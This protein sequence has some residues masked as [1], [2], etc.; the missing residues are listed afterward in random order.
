MRRQECALSTAFVAGSDILLSLLAVSKRYN[1]RPSVI[2]GV[3]NSYDAYCLDEACTYA[4][5]LVEEGRMPGGNEQTVKQL[6]GMKGVEFID[7]SRN[8]KGLSH[9]QQP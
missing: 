6:I 4:M 9:A 3:E 2:V 1:V 7:R 5:C 8:N